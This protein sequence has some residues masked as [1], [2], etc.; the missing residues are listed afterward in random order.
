[1]E[2]IRQTL[3]QKRER[4][5]TPEERVVTLSKQLEESKSQEFIKEKLP[6]LFKLL[7]NELGINILKG[8]EVNEVYRLFQEKKCLVRVENFTRILEALEL[9][10]GF[11]V[12]E[13]ADDSHYANAVIPEPDGIRLA[14]AEGQTSGPFRL[15]MGLGKSL[16]GFNTTSNHLQTFAVDFD[17]EDPRDIAARRRLCRH[18]EGEV[19]KGDIQG[20][21]MRI[22]RNVVEQGLLSEKERLEEGQFVFR[23][24]LTPHDA[25]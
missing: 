9:N 16:V 24:F 17:E 11:R 19:R 4:E 22:P 5:Q 2:R 6:E 1:M 23:G 8:A 25:S 3:P 7:E 10:R 14:F 12:G 13:S 20:V 21:V 18:V 15:A